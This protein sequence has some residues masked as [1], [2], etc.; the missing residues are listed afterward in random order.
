M[1]RALLL[2]WCAAGCTQNQASTNGN[3]LSVDQ[4]MDLS[5]NLDDGLIHDLSV[6][7]TDGSGDGSVDLAAG[8]GADLAGVDFAGADFAG[9]L[10][11]AAPVGVDG[12]ISCAGAQCTQP[13]QFCCWKGASAGASCKTG[14]GT[15]NCG[16]QGGTPIFCDSNATC[17]T[18]RKCCLA[19]GVV[20]CSLTCTGVQLCAPG[21]SECTT[22]TCQPA[23][24]TA[25]P[26]GYYTCQ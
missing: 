7:Q 6:T 19:S 12:Y 3:D 15:T 25:L 10:M 5:V 11:D 24:G 18:G 13:P 8:G 1:S 14:D 21:G 2:A 4:L 17:P 22:G 23:A 26:P 20:D 16:L 9:P